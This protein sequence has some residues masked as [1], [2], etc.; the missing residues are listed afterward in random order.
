MKYLVIDTSTP[1]LVFSIA[2]EDKVLYTFS[3]KVKTDLST[4]FMVVVDNAFKQCNLVPNDID[5]V[6]ISC[7]PGSFTGVRIGM[8]FAK[9][10]CFSLNKGL[11]PFSTLEAFATS[12]NNEYVA[13]LIDARRGY[14]FA[15]IYDSNLKTVFEDKYI[16]L[17][18][19]INEIKKYDNIDIISYNDFENLN[20]L[21]PNIDVLKIIKKHINDTPVNPHSLKPKYLKDTEAEEKLRNDNKN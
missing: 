15:G 11:I 16:M 13:S 17:D 20:I 1:N 8:T 19:L 18:E 2:T 9:I 14:V 6:F 3:S 7:G 4:D 10:F 5:K 12:S 21:T